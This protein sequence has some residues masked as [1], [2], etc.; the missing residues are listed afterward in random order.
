M[1]KPF[2]GPTGPQGQRELRAELR[3]GGGCADTSNPRHVIELGGRSPAPASWDDYLVEYVEEFRPVLMAIKECCEREGIVG[4]T[5]D[6]MANDHYFA[7]EPGGW[8]VSFSWRAWGDLMQS[9]VG[10]GEGYMA[11]YM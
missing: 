2:L 8:E 11:Y 6:A 9:I 1:S 7:V 4:T 10:K 3:H 5:G